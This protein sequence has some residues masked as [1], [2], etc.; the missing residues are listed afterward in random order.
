MHKSVSLICLILS[1]CLASI[2]G[3][4]YDRVVALDGSG[5]FTSI[6]TAIDAAPSNAKAPHTIYIKD[7]VYKEHVCI[8]S[9]KTFIYLIGQ[10]RDGVTI[11]DSRVCGG[12]GIA[13]SPQYG[14]TVVDN[15]NDT[16]FENLTIENSWGVSR[17]TGPQALALNITSDR[18][19]LYNCRLRSYQ[20]TFLTTMTD[21]N[22]HYLKDCEIE[23]AV[24]F[25]YGSGNVFFDECTLKI[26]RESGGWIVAPCHNK[27]KWGYVFK[28]CRITAPGDPSKTSVWFGRPWHNRPLT[29]FIDTVCEV[30]IPKEGWFDHM[31][32]LPLLWADYR[33]RNA[34]GSLQDLSQ[35]RTAY[36]GT[37]KYGNRYECK[38]KNFLTDEEAAQYTVANVL[39]GS[40][41]WDPAKIAGYTSK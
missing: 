16:Y 37:D 40:D 27:T 1:A 35:R 9:D 6:Q 32:G 11:S 41:G 29:V 25:I 14:A 8:H 34:D 24:D 3:K 31:G 20:D 2:P 39:S 17:Q 38:A 13:Y 30:G 22:R 26:M 15:A 28:D 19:V 21:N 7:G 33:T 10:S 5:D 18:V 36:Y 23:G 4:A 12:D